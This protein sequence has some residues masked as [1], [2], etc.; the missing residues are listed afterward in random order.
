M[1]VLCVGMQF[2]YTYGTVVAVAAHALHRSRRPIRGFGSSG[3]PSVVDRPQLLSSS[4]VSTRGNGNV[5]LHL[6]RRIA[7]RCYR[8]EFPLVG[9]VPVR[10]ATTAPCRLSL[11]TAPPRLASP[12]ASV[13]DDN[14]KPRRPSAVPT[15]HVRPRRAPRHLA[16]TFSS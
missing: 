5:S 7:R 13:H 9:S 12:L 16:F 14:D 11:S 8:E 4:A 15:S 6:S 10:A 1:Y 3:P 2:R